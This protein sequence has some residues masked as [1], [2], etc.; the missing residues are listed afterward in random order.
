MHLKI[1]YKI[2]KVGSQKSSHTENFVKEYFNDTN[3]PTIYIHLNAKNMKHFLTCILVFCLLSVQGQN[4]GSSITISMPSQMPAQTTSWPTAMPPVGI[5]VQ[6]KPDNNRAIPKE[7]IESRILVT[8]KNG[9]DKICG[10]YTPSAAPNTGFNSL[11]KSWRGADVTQLLGQDCTLKPGSYTLCVQ[12]FNYNGKQLSEESCKP[13]IVKEEAGTASDL[14]YQPAQAISP[15]DGSQ[16]SE[17]ESK[18]P[19]SFRW[20]PIIPKPREAILYTVEVI[21]VPKG[22]SAGSGQFTV[23]YK[24]AAIAN[25]TQ[26]VVPGSVAANWPVAAGSSYAWYVSASGKEGKSYGKSNVNTFSITNGGI[27][28][29]MAA[30][31]QMDFKIISSSCE[32]D[33]TTGLLYYKFCANLK[34][35]ST[36]P[37]TTMYFNDPLTF[38]CVN[39]TLTGCSVVTL[40]DLIKSPNG[41]ISYI[42]GFPNIIPKTGFG[43]M[44]CFK[45]TPTVAAATTATLKAFGVCATGTGVAAQSSGSATPDTLVKLPPCPCTYCDQFKQW[46][47]EKEEVKTIT[48]PASASHP[49]TYGVN[50][51]TVIS[52][53]VINIKSFKAELISF[54]HDGKEECF[55][56]N[57]DAQTFGNFTGGTF[58]SWGNGV[59]P[60]SGANTTH[61]TLSWFGASGVTIPMAG[62]AINLQ[63]TVPPFSTLSCCD[64]E[65]KFCIRYSF[66][67]ADC[68]TCSFV[69]CYSVTRKHQ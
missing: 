49:A 39:G 4:Q 62:Q 12:I 1:D 41:T 5:T 59:F 65:I 40:S 35:I 69:K 8:I 47:F 3:K 14:N 63:F 22:E 61:H 48:T 56:C 19:I 9:S 16:M 42:G 29:I 36:V 50:V 6:L 27:N 58:G 64:D 55:G 54:I 24:S 32:K 30:G 53:P 45:Y 46:G 13:F 25:Q 20:T 10:S 21:E 15:A 31:C 33:P 7:F 57:K 28:K 26:L 51:S 68:Q 66:T 44:V 23:L 43:A 17:M 34:D 2:N 38:N 18:K 52:G 11:V 37:G 60:L 67:N